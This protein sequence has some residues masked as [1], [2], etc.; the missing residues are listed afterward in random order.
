VFFPA[1]SGDKKASRDCSFWKSRLAGFESFCAGFL[2]FQHF[3]PTFRRPALPEGEEAVR[4]SE[5]K[6]GACAISHL[7]AVS[8]QPESI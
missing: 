2:R 5:V 3:T 7:I 8:V 6:V 4:K 1:L